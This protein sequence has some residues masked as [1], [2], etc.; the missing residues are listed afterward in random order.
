MKRHSNLQR[1]LVT[2]GLLGLSACASMAPTHASTPAAAKIV[3]QRYL[4]YRVGINISAPPSRIWALLTDA[5]GYPAWNSTIVEIEGRIAQ[6]EEIHLTAQIDPSRTFDLTVSTYEENR[7]LV[8]GDGGA[9]FKGVRTFELR[10]RTDGTTDVTMV[11]VMTGS[12]MGFIEDELQNGPA[13]PNTLFT[14]VPGSGLA[15][16]D[17]LFVPPEAP[18]A[19]PQVS[20]IEPAG[21]PEV[22]PVPRRSC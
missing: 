17:G 13:K 19:P 3:G 10:V 21:R 14:V 1:L 11:E 16:V 20:A 22:A 8:W 15:E 4:Q 5:P 2:I 12:M 18:A 7:R 6:D 9:M